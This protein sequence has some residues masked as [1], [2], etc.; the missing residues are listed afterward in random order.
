MRVID[1]PLTL[2]DD[3]KKYFSGYQS[4]L[5]VSIVKNKKKNSKGFGYV[6]FGK[7]EDAKKAIGCK[8]KIF[9]K[10]VIFTFL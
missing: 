6:K 7:Q 2:L 1:F 4:F 3:L 5:D 10:M 9:G 8:H